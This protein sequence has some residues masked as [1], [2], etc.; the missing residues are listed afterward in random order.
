MGRSPIYF[1]AIKDEQSFTLTFTNMS[2]LGV[3]T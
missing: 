1:R 3:A 2:K